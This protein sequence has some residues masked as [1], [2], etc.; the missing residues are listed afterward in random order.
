MAQIKKKCFAIFIVYIESKQNVR[1]RA[2]D[3]RKYVLI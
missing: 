1:E 3:L 2:M